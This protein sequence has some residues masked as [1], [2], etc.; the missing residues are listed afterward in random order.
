MIEA[1]RVEALAVQGAAS[2]VLTRAVLGTG[3]SVPFAIPPVVMALIGVYFTP[4]AAV[5]SMLA[6]GLLIACGAA[7]YWPINFLV[8]ILGAVGIGGALNAAM[9]W[10]DAFTRPLATRSA[11][12][13]R[14]PAKRRLKQAKSEPTDNNGG[15]ITLVI[16]SVLA[17]II[18]ALP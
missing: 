17:S 14:R 8:L 12:A 7:K 10:I 6:A 3:L 11:P 13:R 15:L 9:Q 1:A 4:V 2:I 18:G 16:G 5:E